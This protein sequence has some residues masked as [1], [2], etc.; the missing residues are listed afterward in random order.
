MIPTYDTDFWSPAF[1]YDEQPDGS[2]LMAQT[3]ALPDH[4]QLLADY[5]DHWAAT[6]PDRTW[7]ARRVEGGDWTRI[8]YAQGLDTVRRLGA[9]LLDLGL[10][11]DRPL[12]ILSEN[13]LEHALLGM[14][15]VYVG[16]PY[17]PVSPAYSL[18]SKDHGKLRDIATLLTPGAVFADDAK[19]FRTAFAAIAAPDRHEITLDGD[20]TYASLLDGD[21]IKAD[22]ARARLTPDTVAKYLFTSGSTG[23][24]K[25]VINTNGMI[26]AMQALV[27]DCY[28][29]LTHR[30]PVTLDWAPWNH[31]AAGNKVFYLIMTN[32][33]TYY[34][35][36]GRPAPG[37]ID[38]TLRNL[39]E[40]SCTW[41][42]QRAR[43]L[44]PADRRTG[45]GRRPVRNL[46]QRPRHDVLRRC[47]HG[48]AH[49]GPTETGQPQG[50]RTG[51]AAGD[52]VWDRPK[53]R[54]LH[55]PAPTP[56]TNPATWACPRGGWC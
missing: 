22:A 40:V 6:A 37:K 19:A 50:D 18:V 2:V 36:D 7:L 29:F 17:A 42:F 46:F 53:P 51:S 10:T 47:G 23:S 52:R 13:S 30:P 4:P 5:L 25:A 3:G 41:Y 20:L 21:P 26:T 8:S 44:G 1:T 48:A 55:W 16:V 15:C 31:T 56:R 11:P 39:R 28:R 45:S 35:D 38:E 34:I 43:R 9:S 12:L 54:P 49:V 27:R 14:A 24:P 32:G 33:G